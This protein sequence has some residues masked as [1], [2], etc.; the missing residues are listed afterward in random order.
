MVTESGD[1]FNETLD[2]IKNGS[3]MTWQHIN[4]LG[5]YDFNLLSTTNNEPFKMDSIL[6]MRLN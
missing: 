1:H 6:K 5:E 4:M 2:I 3:I